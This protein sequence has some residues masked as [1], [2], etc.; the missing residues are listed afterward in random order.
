MHLRFKDAVKRDYFVSMKIDIDYSEQ[1]AGD[2]AKWKASEYD[3]F[4]PLRL[5]C[6][7]SL[8][9]RAACALNV[10]QPNKLAQPSKTPLSVIC[11]APSSFLAIYLFLF[12]FLAHF[13]SLFFIYFKDAKTHGQI[14]GKRATAT[15]HGGGA[16]PPQQPPKSRHNTWLIFFNK[17][18]DWLHWFVDDLLQT[19]PTPSA[20]LL[21]Q[22][23]AR[24]PARV[25]IM[26][27]LFPFLPKFNV[28][29]RLIL[30]IRWETGCSGL[31]IICCRPHLQLVPTNQQLARSLVRE[32]GN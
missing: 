31:W 6:M 1:L 9:K 27:F 13:F 22:Q 32:L 17:M 18:G 15:S 10:M 8:L 2:W 4:W 20:H 12:L 7:S 29:V 16:H 24:S 26:P 14:D 30:S 11:V 3:T 5:D 19:S 25:I 21:N 23:P 28:Q